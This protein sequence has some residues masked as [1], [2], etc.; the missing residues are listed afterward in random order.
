MKSL[1]ISL[2][3]TIPPLYG[4]DGKGSNALAF[5]KLFTPD[6]NFTW[7]ITEYDADEKI[8]FGL[9][10]GFEKELGYFSLNEI[11]QIKGPMGLEVERDILFQPTKLKNLGFDDGE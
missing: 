3:N 5:V 4:Q 9:I 6:S 8:C 2:I 10:D 11:E 7:Y 1:P